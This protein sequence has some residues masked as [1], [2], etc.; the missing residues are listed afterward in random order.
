MWPIEVIMINLNQYVLIRFRSLI[1][2]GDGALTQSDSRKF[3]FTNADVSALLAI[4]IKA[5]SPKLEIVNQSNQSNQLNHNANLIRVN[6]Y[7]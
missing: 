1:L 6:T 7:R 4:V 3:W 5:I 2:F